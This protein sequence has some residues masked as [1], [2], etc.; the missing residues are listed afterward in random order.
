MGEGERQ[1]DEG[2]KVKV[3]E[4]IQ[5]LSKN[6]EIVIY[7]WFSSD[8]R[9]SSLWYGTVK[10]W[11]EEGCQFGDQETESIQ[12]SASGIKAIYLEGKEKEMQRKQE[13]EN[14]IL[15]ER[16]ERV[17]ETLRLRGEKYNA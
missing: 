7:G 17:K 4:I 15:I 3:E 2:D 9:Y 10:K 5:P 13:K 8:K 6:K 11:K 12:E 16:R 1:W 14:K